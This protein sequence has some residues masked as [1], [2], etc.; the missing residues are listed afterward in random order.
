MGAMRGRFSFLLASLVLLVGIA[1]ETFSAPASGA[2][3]GDNVVPQDVFDGM[4]ESFQPAKA[5]GVHLR[6]EFDLSGPHGGNWW[7]EIS[8][9]KFK[10][11]H[12]KIA[13]P[14]VVFSTSDK[15]WVALA[16]GTLSGTWATITG[17]LQVHGSH[18]LAR[19]LDE[20][21]P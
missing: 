15:D 1:G 16:N 6:Y 12:G 7:I 13:N 19:K 17:R 21:C 11:G 18:A 4:R 2:R 9:G 8:D 10:M 5:K 3:A 20:M 14:N